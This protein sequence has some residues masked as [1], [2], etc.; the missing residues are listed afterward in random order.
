MIAYLE[1]RLTRKTPSQLLVL[2]GGVG[3]KLF[4][5]VSTYY[6]LPE[7][8]SEV[9]LH[10]H[11]HVRED[12]LALYGFASATE[13]RLFQRL[14]AVN[15]VGPALALK[16]MS[17]LE[18]SALVDAI[19]SSDLRRLGSIPGVGRKTA[20][21]LVV[22]LRDKMAELGVAS[23]DGTSRAPRDPAESLRD[24]LLSALANLGFPRPSA[25]KS[26]EAA[27]REEPEISFEAALKKVLRK[28]SG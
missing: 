25:E 17:G 13:E 8:G 28:L 11:T 5:P 27:V 12:L 15:G 6:E 14:I 22:E 7:E 21:R 24:D 18:P 2:V 9:R 20:E 23:G 1:G 19:R 4:I 3:Y 10:V 16:V 26:V